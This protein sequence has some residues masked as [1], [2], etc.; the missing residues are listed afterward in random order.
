M[1]EN[2]RIRLASV[3]AQPQLAALG[4]LCGLM[5]GAI[6]LLFRQ[7][8]E[9]S[10]TGFLPDGNTENY[11]ALSVWVRFLLPSVG[12][13]ILGLLFQFGFRDKQQV[14]IVH[15]MERLAYH[16]SHLPLR[17]GIAQFF[18]AA[19]SIISGHSV[20]RE[21]P[22]VHLGATS[23][24]M[25]GLWLQLPNNSN[26]TLVACGIAAAIGAS[27]NTPLAGVIFAMEVIMMEYT[28]AGFV[29]VILAAVSGTAL[30]RFVYGSSPAFIVPA[31]EFNSIEELPLVLIMGICIGALAALFIKLQVF[32]T[33]FLSSQPIWQRMTLAGVLTGV[34][35]VFVPQI[36]GI[37]YDTVNASLVGELGM[38]LMLSVVFIKI[39][40]TAAG[41]GLG[42][43][44]GMIG[45]TL[46]IG[47]TAGGVLGILGNSF[48]PGDLTSHTFYAMI[49]MGAMMGATLQA[50]LSALVAMLELTA[51]PNIILPGM[52]A[53]IASGLTASEL[54]GRTS[55]FLTLMRARGLEYRSD[56][57]TQ[58]LQRTGI[59]SIMN[60]RFLIW[61]PLISRD[62]LKSI[63]RGEA[64]W[65]LIE[66]NN[67][68]VALID[69]SQLE[70]MLTEKPD[71][72]FNL[73]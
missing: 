15:V 6:I 37:G 52:L 61:P 57:L 20:G 21:G 13:L 68:I 55:I 72:H 17:N 50:P 40:A 48:L 49:G 5:S 7:F 60:T 22:S 54:F 56:P 28:L 33:G 70:Q 26:R 46:V 71:D 35:A 39:F 63:I 23:G 65:L 34:C 42:L 11:E 43:P 12:G 47:A 51:N 67:Q 16:H 10:Q 32:F 27:F 41:L 59:A 14:G 2:F 66:D 31:L 25:I 36:M 44:G 3:N 64:V 58:A 24:S 18:G 4:L 53:V 73:L 19:I 9:Q 45:P 29:P 38:G 8:I 1:L 30:L 69:I 62:E